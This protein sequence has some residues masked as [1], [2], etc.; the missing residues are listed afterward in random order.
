MGPQPRARRRQDRGHQAGQRARRRAGL[1]GR[2]AERRRPRR[3]V[4]HVAGGSDRPHR[5]GDA[6]RR[7]ERGRPAEAVSDPAPVAIHEDRAPKAAPAIT[8]AAYDEAKADTG[9]FI[10]Y[11]NQLLPYVRL[12]AAEQIAFKRYAG[13][14]MVAG[15]PYDPAKM[16]SGVVAAID[17][18]V[19]EARGKLEKAMSEVRGAVDPVGTREAFGGDSMKRS[20]SAG[21][22]LHR[23]AR[24]EIVEIPIAGDGGGDPFEKGAKY[25]LVFPPGQLPPVDGFWS[26]EMIS[27]PDVRFFENPVNRFVIDSRMT[28]LKKNPDGSIEI[29]IQRE[30][31]GPDSSRTGC[32][33]ANPVS[34]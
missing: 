14:G 6:R 3:A 8:F 19:T 4:G 33:R 1:E 23:V 26:L 30:T 22:D 10:G 32:P 28:G 24:N 31:P 29:A 9:A 13:I 21:F 12:D 16:D 11:V 7:R 25:R 5:R 20:I 18:G 15:K 2:A 34:R 27:V 17:S